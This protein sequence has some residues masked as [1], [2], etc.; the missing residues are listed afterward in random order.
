MSSGPLA[1]IVKHFK[2][3]DSVKLEVFDDGKKSGD[4]IILLLFESL[5][6]CQ[7]ARAEKEG[8]QI[9]NRW[10]NLTPARYSEHETYLDE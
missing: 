10:I 3:G 9:G 6:E 2:F 4:A 7:R 5:V 1:F 8:K